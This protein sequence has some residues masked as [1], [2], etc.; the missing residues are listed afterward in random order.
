MEHVRRIWMGEAAKNKIRME[1]FGEII[2]ERVAQ[3]GSDRI[4]QRKRDSRNRRQLNDSDELRQAELDAECRRKAKSRR[5][6]TE[7]LNIKTIEERK[8]LMEKVNQGY[9][10]Y[11]DS[12]QDP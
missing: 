3:F 11:T 7:S 4:T 12:F 9:P 5:L 1:E 6:A 8:A 2:P 10:F